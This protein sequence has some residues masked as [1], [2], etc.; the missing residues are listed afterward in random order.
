[1]SVD[2]SKETLQARKIGRNI[3]LLLH[4]FLHSLV[5]SSMCPDLG[6]NPNLVVSEMMLYPTELPS[7][8]CLSQFNKMSLFLTFSAYEIL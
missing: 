8:G 1:M 5:D 7:Q 2:F 3:Y 6:S 4:F